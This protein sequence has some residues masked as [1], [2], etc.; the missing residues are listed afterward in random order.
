MTCRRCRKHVASGEARCP[1]CGEPQPDSGVFKTST[2][3]I[4]AGGSDRVFES[5]EEV[6]PQLREALRESTRGRD[7]ATIV[8]A[9]RL[10][11]RELLGAQPDT[12]PARS[13]GW[14]SPRW[15]LPIALILAG[16]ALAAAVLAFRG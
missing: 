2:V 7:S 15:R 14:L 5:V 6:P 11:R 3:W 16:A 8:I 1:H 10:G 4:S 9:D 13:P 12:P